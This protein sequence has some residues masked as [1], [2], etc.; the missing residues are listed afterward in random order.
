MIFDISYISTNNFGHADVLSRLIDRTSNPTENYVIAAVKFESEIHQILSDSISKL[1]VTHKMVKYETEKDSNLQEVTQCT[2]GWP[3]TL[4]SNDE[5]KQ[6]SNR[7]NELSLV[8]G[9]LMFGNRIVIPKIFRKRII[10]Q[11][12]KG[13]PGIERTKSIARSF[14]YW[15]NNNNNNNK[16]ETQG[17]SLNSCPASGLTEAGFSQ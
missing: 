3:N 6:F 12:H 4:E 8:N 13:H 15:P 7:K 2:N 16:S 14:V 5:I 1:P 17:Q 10:K 9:C 11:L